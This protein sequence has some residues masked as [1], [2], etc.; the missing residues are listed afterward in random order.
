MAQYQEFFDKKTP[1]DYEIARFIKSNIH[2]DDTIFVWGNNAQLYQLVGVIPPTKYIVAYHITSYS[3]GVSS[4]KAS[5]EKTKP[6]FIV[7]MPNQ[8]G[9]PFPLINYS[10][11]ININKAIIY[12]RIF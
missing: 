4:T 6:R 7:A 9:I 5:L 2:K 12:E 8:G 10:K 1:F 3:D 11:K